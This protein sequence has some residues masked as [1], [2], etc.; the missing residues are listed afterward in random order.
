MPFWRV[1]C[2]DYNFPSMTEEKTKHY[3]YT[4]DYKLAVLKDVDKGEMSIRKYAKK[5]GIP[6]SCIRDWKKAAAGIRGNKK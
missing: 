1:E 2:N 3:S 6:E 4:V 5:H